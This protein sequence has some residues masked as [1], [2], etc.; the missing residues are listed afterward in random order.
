[1]KAAAQHADAAAKRNHPPAVKR[2][3]E[4]RSHFLDHRFAVNFEAQKRFAAA[5][6]SI[7]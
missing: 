7:A 3:A 6:N 5:L 4:S 1:M 2:A